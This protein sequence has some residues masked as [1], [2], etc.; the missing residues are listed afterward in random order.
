[1]KILLDRFI[2]PKI[3]CFVFLVGSKC[4]VK[5]GHVFQDICAGI[6]TSVRTGSHQTLTQKNK[7][8]FTRSSKANKS[9]CLALGQS[10]S[11]L[12]LM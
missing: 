6:S 12:K 1:M 11:L 10:I 9:S 3:R 2:S 4:F 7:A 5:F 8:V